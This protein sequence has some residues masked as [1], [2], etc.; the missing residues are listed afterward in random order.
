MWMGGLPLEQP[1]K[2]GSPAGPRD[3]TDLKARLGL[4][5]GPAAGGPPGAAPGRAPFPGAPGGA[6][7]GAPPQPFPPAGNQG[8]PNQGG[9][10]PGMGG[11]QMHAP[12]HQAPAPYLFVMRRPP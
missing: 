10:P 1:K 9:M 3:I 4:N 12:M 2:P 8:F 6:M 7:P 5:R 11:Q